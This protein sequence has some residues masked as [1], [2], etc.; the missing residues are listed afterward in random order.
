MRTQ[1]L[2]IFAAHHLQRNRQQ[3]LLAQRIF[4]QQPFALV[5]TNLGLGHPSPKALRGPRRC[6]AD[7]T[8]SQIPAPHLPPPGRGSAHKA[9]PG[10]SQ[11]SLKPDVLDY[12]VFAVVFLDQLGPPAADAAACAAVR[13]APDRWHPGGN[14]L[15]EVDRMML[16]I[17]YFDEHREPSAAP[18]KYRE[19]PRKHAQRRKSLQGAILKNKGG[20]K[21]CQ[22]KARAENVACQ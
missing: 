22:E 8:A 7:G 14:V 6:P 16:Q 17:S 9:L 15:P 1:A 4:Q 21:G 12:L 13:P 11:A 10:W 19:G 5:I 18:P 20:G 3:N 2:A